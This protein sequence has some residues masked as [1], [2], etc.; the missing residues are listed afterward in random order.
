MSLLR[1]RHFHFPSQSGGSKWKHERVMTGESSRSGLSPQPVSMGPLLLRR[2]KIVSS[3]LLSQLE[4]FII[5]FP[6]KIWKDGD[7]YPEKT[8]WLFDAIS[9]PPPINTL[10]CV[11]LQAFFPPEKSICLAQLVLKKWELKQT[12]GFIS[13]WN[14]LFSRSPLW[15]LK[16]NINLN[17]GLL[18]FKNQDFLVPGPT[19]PGWGV[20]RQLQSAGLCQPPP[21]KGGAPALREDVIH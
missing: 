14:K 17:S 3:S 5:Y 9:P 7:S 2:R 15:Q 11:H 18:A 10:G 12:A 8:L 1:K 4:A 6:I 20:G 13:T 16:A 21:Q 19:K